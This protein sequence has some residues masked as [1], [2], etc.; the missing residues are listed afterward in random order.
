MG[1]GFLSEVMR[2]LWNHIVMMFKQHCECTKNHGMV[3]VK[4]VKV[5]LPDLNK[6]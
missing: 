2:I 5:M 1:M 3:P 4:M 6:F